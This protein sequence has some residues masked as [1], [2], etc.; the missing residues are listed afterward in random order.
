MARPLAH[1]RS[2]RGQAMVEFALGSMVIITVLIFA[3][4]FA[5]ISYLSL[6]V[7]EASHS[8]LLDATGHKLHDWPEDA[9][10]AGTAARIAGQKAAERY[11]DFDGRQRSTGGTTLTQAFTQATSMRVDCEGNGGPGWGPSF[12][13]SL[14][15]DENG[16]ISCTSQ[17]D[18]MAVEIPTE[19]LEDA[20]N[21]FF[22]RQHYQATPIHVCGIGRA[23]GGA[24]PGQLTSMLDDWGL[25]GPDESGNCVIVPNVPTCLTNTKYWTMAASVHLTTGAGLGAA[26]SSMAMGT[27]GAMP[28]PLFPFI[29]EN[30]FWMSSVGEPIFVQPLLGES[31]SLTGWPTSPGP[32]PGGFAGLPYSVAY[33]QRDECFLGKDCPP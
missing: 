15:Y 23:S 3:I 33:F 17:A 2:A 30:M 20:N 26:A 21:G 6:K 28:L 8:A 4:H 11:G 5:E 32:V 22:K 10:P 9:S 31:N 7:T 14:A 1:R 25:S 13:T 19:F 24:C 27:V 18:I 29:T 12:F 16:G